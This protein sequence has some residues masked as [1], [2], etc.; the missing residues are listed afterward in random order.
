MSMP[1]IFELRYCMFQKEDHELQRFMQ[2]FELFG[3]F[4]AEFIFRL[5]VTQVK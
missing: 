4:A 5:L 1:A 3:V 2:T